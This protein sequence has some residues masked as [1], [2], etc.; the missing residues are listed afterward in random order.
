[1]MKKKIYTALMV[2]FMLI[3]ITACGQKETDQPS[4]NVPTESASASLPEADVTEEINTEPV[5]TQPAV[6]ENTQ[7][8]ASLEELSKML[9]QSD[10]AVKDLFGGGTENKTEDG[11]VL[12]GR[13]YHSTLFGNNVTI[14]TMYDD[15]EKVSMVQAE[16]PD[17]DLAECQK[18]ITKAAGT[19]M[20]STSSDESGQGK[21]QW[22]YDGKL[23]SLFQTENLLF[24]EIIV[25]AE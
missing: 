10:D 16:L 22:S 3:T 4:S 23:I 12:I 1:M 7:E 21:G 17:F 8:Q 20:E 2:S 18:E 15:T 19:E 9:G 5:Q 13:D 14:H 11:S 24:M 25:P 6:S